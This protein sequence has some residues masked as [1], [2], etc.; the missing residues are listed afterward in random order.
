M[1]ATQS[2]TMLNQFS[3]DEVVIA[4]RQAGATELHRPDADA[5]EYEDWLEDYTLGQLWETNVLDGGYPRFESGAP[6]KTLP[7]IKPAQPRLSSPVGDRKHFT[8]Y[9]GG[10]VQCSISSCLASSS[11]RVWIFSE[12]K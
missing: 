6:Q 10:F 4:S 3:I 8:P 7:D 9:C 11:F 12:D 5:S 2:V 1:V